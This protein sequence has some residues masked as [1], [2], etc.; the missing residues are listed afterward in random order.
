[1]KNNTSHNLQSLAKSVRYHRYAEQRYNLQPDAIATTVN[2]ALVLHFIEHDLSKAKAMYKKALKTSPQNVLVL[3]GLALLELLRNSQ[4][5]A[6]DELLLQ[7]SNVSKLHPQKSLA[8]L[9]DIFFRFSLVQNPE[10]T[11]ALLNL[12][13]LKHYVNENAYESEK[14]YARAVAIDSTTQSHEV[15]MS[16]ISLKFLMIGHKLY[17]VFLSQRWP[18]ERYA[19]TGPSRCAET[20]GTKICRIGHWEKCSIQHGNKTIIFW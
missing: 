17:N 18:G 2:Y 11:I 8:D 13:L 7:A 3:Q 20:R 1:M 15:R 10:C 19:Q 9:E 5:K 6:A 12:A 16:T 14:F 4:S